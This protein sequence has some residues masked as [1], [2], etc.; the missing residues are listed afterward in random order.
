MAHDPVQK[1]LE[2]RLAKAGYFYER[3]RGQ[4]DKLSKTEKKPF[5]L[6]KNHYR[7]I[8]AEDLA[9]S[10]MVW[11]GKPTEA[12]SS[13]SAHFIR[14]GNQGFYESIF[15][16]SSYNEFDFI[17]AFWLLDYCEEQRK[18]FASKFRGAARKDFEGLPEE[19]VLQLRAKEYLLHAETHMAALMGSAIRKVLERERYAALIQLFEEQNTSPFDHL[20]NT[21]DAIISLKYK[22]EFS[23]ARQ[24]GQLLAPQFSKDFKNKEFWQELQ[25]FV[26]DQLEMWSITADPMERFK[27]ELAKVGIKTPTTKS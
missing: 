21:Y 2:A 9:K 1:T 6:R 25:S 15:N 24:S 18:R 5:N 4:W 17:L 20:F 10:T 8:R 14:E 26:R 12:K 13:K 22:R 11:M 27:A 23:A 19:E 3:M 7:R 16:L